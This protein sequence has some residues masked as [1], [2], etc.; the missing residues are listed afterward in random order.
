MTDFV[1]NFGKI[2]FFVKLILIPSTIIYFVVDIIS[3]LYL[4]HKEDEIEITKILQIINDVLFYIII[5]LLVVICLFLLIIFRNKSIHLINHTMKD[6]GIK[7]K[8]LPKKKKN[9]PTLSLELNNYYESLTWWMIFYL[10]I[11]TICA[12]ISKIIHDPRFVYN[13]F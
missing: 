9:H 12:L 5:G 13:V 10:L 6:L 7:K 8:K 1:Q 4:K 2:L 3:H 11:I